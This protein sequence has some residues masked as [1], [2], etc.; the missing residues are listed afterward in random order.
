AFL[1]VVAA[2]AVVG[3]RVAMT[4]AAA[5]AAEGT[6]IADVARAAD[7]RDLHLAYTRGLVAHVGAA[8]GVCARRRGT[9]AG[10]GVIARE[11]AGCRAARAAVV[12][13]LVALFTAVRAYDAV[14]ARLTAVHARWTGGGLA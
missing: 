1:T 12:S 14:A 13:P 5:G 7:V 11:R 4:V 8:V 6:W 10:V 2:A 3:L 9:T